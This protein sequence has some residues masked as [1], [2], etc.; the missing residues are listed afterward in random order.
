MQDNEKLVTKFSAKLDESQKQ[1][2]NDTISSD[3]CTKLV[4]ELINSEELQACAEVGALAD[5][6]G[7]FV[8]YVEVQ[9]LLAKKLISLGNRNKAN[10]ILGNCEIYLGEDDHELQYK[11][12]K[13]KWQMENGV[14]ETE[15]PKPAATAKPAAVPKAA[16]PKPAATPKPAVAAKPAA[17][18]KPAAAA[19]SGDNGKQTFPKTI[20]PIGAAAAVILFGAFFAF[21][22][23]ESEQKTVPTNNPASTVETVEK[24]AKLVTVKF[25][26]PDGSI[27]L[28]DGNKYQSNEQVKLTLGKHKLDLQ[29]PL[30]KYT[31][32]QEINI[33]ET[34]A[35]GVL[36][37]IKNIEPS[38]ALADNVKQADMAII[39]DILQQAVNNDKMMLVPELYTAEANKNNMLT[40]VHAAL[41]K[42]GIKDVHVNQAK[43]GSIQLLNTDGG[44][45]F[46]VKTAEPVELEGKN[47]DGKVFRY[48]VQTTLKID[49]GKLLLVS[50]DKFKVTK[51]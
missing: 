33:T 9:L 20:L 41:K 17:V 8:K 32:D 6:R 4:D 35:A 29:H 11:L 45:T 51:L 14:V 13:L 36:E 50:L 44:K 18:P 27:L 34:S 23:G 10:E 42:A 7:L 26:V 48:D 49:A 15:V 46:F 47:K 38:A 31:Y 25:N 39:N 3:G 30:L 40:K 12:E 37:I 19:S 2:L 24:K 28:I 5:N 43:L 22:G 16:A 21:S 1:L